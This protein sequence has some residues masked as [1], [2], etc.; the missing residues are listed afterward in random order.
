MFDAIGHQTPL[1]MR[2]EY[3]TVTP[4]R[5]WRCER[6]VHKEGGLFNLIPLPDPMNRDAKLRGANPKNPTG[7]G[8]VVARDLMHVE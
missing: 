3:V 5:E 4:N 1:W 7:H 6:R 8:G 2:C